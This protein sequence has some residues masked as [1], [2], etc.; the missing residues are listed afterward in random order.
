MVMGGREVVRQGERERAVIMI[1][2]FFIL[3]FE[4]EKQKQR[5][6]KTK[7]ERKKETLLG[8]FLFQV[9]KETELLLRLLFVFCLQNQQ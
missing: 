4:E 1:N 5:K 7:K 3:L 2:Y 6:K 8:L 9:S